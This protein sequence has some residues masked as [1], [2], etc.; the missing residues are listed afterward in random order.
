MICAS[1]GDDNGVENEAVSLE[2]LEEF[3]TSPI[4]DNGSCISSV[5]VESLEDDRK[6]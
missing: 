2:I 4:G 1:G 6:V 3:K 5:M